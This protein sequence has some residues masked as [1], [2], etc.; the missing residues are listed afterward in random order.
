MMG[1]RAGGSYVAVYGTL[2]EGEI[3]ERWR[4]GIGT[5]TKG[6]MFGT[7]FDTG[8]GF[9]AFFQG[10]GMA[11]QTKVEC[12]VLFASEQEIARMDVLEGYPT[13]YRREK[14]TV[15]GQ[16]D[17]EYECLVYVM[18]RLPQGA[19]PIRSGKWCAY[20]RRVEKAK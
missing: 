13:L 3:N 4:V 7:L 6:W 16:D 14:V 5:V 17:K 18:N 2:M 9:P 20:R 12:E 15:Y 8:Y 1:K 19:K 10:C 11:R